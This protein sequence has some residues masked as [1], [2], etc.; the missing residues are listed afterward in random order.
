MI[1]LAV[2]STQ[3]T[4]DH[5]VSLG[6]RVYDSWVANLVTRPRQRQVHDYTVRGPFQ[7]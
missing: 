2:M 6:A 4:V 5:M 3:G 7:C 1:E